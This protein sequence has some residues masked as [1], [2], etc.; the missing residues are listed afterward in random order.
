MNPNQLITSAP[1][2]LQKMAEE[3][4]RSK[5]A[6]AEKQPVTRSVSDAEIA[7]NSPNT[8][9]RQRVPSGTSSVGRQPI[10]YIGTGSEYFASPSSRS[11]NQH[12]YCLIAGLGIVSTDFGY[13]QLP[14]SALSSASVKRPSAKT[15]EYTY[16]KIISNKTTG[17]S[18]Q[19]LNSLGPM[20]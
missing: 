18:Q 13:E 19:S 14:S 5:R 16:D 12:D 10:S 15:P 4:Q 3:Q 7:S 11:L 17:L 9:V 20:G 2:L 8:H 1:F 6:L